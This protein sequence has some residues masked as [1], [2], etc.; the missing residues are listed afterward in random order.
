[1][2]EADAAEVAQA[3]GGSEV[4]AW[5]VEPC[6]TTVCQSYNHLMTAVH[7]PCNR[8]VNTM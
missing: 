6:F 2:E 1:M 7:Q 8:R 3:E 4:E 5:E